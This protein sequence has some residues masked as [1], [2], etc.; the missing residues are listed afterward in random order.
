MTTDKP[1]TF[2]ASFMLIA[3]GHIST[4]G[5]LAAPRSCVQGFFQKLA[6]RPKRQLALLDAAFC[7][8]QHTGLWCEQFYREPYYPAAFTY[9][10]F[11]DK[12]IKN[13]KPSFENDPCYVHQVV[14]VRSDGAERYGTVP[15]CW[16]I[17]H[18]DRPWKYGGQPWHEMK[19]HL[20]H[21]GPYR[22]QMAGSVVIIDTRLAEA[23]ELHPAGT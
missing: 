6:A 15:K 11:C 22:N 3:D 14:F 5:I 13:L 16:E 23:A 9:M 17:T 4:G 1:T 21:L 12:F 18:D 7:V 10:E 19:M 8:S 2:D 20:R